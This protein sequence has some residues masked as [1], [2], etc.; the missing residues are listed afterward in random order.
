MTHLI[1][2]M[3]TWRNPEIQS[4]TCTQESRRTEGTKGYKG[5]LQEAGS[6]DSQDR[7]QDRPEEAPQ[8]R[9]R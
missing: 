8:A 1:D 3:L 4:K 6:D 2:Y 7:L 5:C 9:Q